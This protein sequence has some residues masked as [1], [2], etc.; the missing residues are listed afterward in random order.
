M[1]SSPA[2]DARPGLA[3][4]GQ[5]PLVEETVSLRHTHTPHDTEGEQTESL[6]GKALAGPSEI[7]PERLGRYRVLRLLGEGTFGRVWLAMDDELRRQVAIKVL[8]SSQLTDPAG[9]EAWL[10]EARALAALDHPH[11]VPVYD[12]GRAEDGSVYAVAKFIAGKT[13]QQEI[14]ERQGPVE[15]AAA[16]AIIATLA[17]ALHHAHER[18]LIHRDV[19][20]A[21][22]LIEQATG[23]VYLADFGL[24][25]GPENAE[26]GVMAG[27]PAYMSPEQ[28][29]CG[30][31]DSRSDLYSLGIVFYELLSGRRPFSGQ[32]VDELFLQV[33]SGIFPPLSAVEESIPAE[34]AR[35]CQKALANDPE[36]RGL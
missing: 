14:K 26:A 28:A 21:N 16:V 32:T 7:A 20:P 23:R 10:A 17:E 2:D 11:I 3:L 35:I 34:L 13:L 31:V 24:A 33:R 36:G 8:F 1:S 27:T 25:T 15:R 18:Q 5:P 9:A 12:V 6:H 22:V 19:K 4:K 30:V 29:Q